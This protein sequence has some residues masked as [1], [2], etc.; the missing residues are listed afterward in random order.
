MKDKADNSCVRGKYELTQAYKSNDEFALKNDE[1]CHPGCKN[2]AD[3]VLCSPTNYGFQLTNWKCVL[4]KCT[5]CSYISLPV[6][7][8]DSSNL[9]PII[10]FNTYMTQLLDYIMAS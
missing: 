2:V 5:A 10:M 9:S 8:R 1:T 7:E 3:Y 6:V 4:Q